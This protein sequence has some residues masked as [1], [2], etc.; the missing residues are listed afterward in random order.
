[1]LIDRL[2]RKYGGTIEEIL[3]H[4]ARA[5]QQLDHLEH[6]DERRDELRQRLES[7]TAEYDEAAK[8][9]SS[10]RRAAARQ[11]ERLVRDEL[12]QVGMEKTR[13]EI[14]FETRSLAGDAPVTLSP[15]RADEVSV[16]DQGPAAASGS[17]AASASAQANDRS[18]AVSRGGARGI[19]EIELRISPNPGEEPRPP[20]KIAS[21]GELSRL[22]L[23]LK[24]VV[25]IARSGGP[26]GAGR[27]TGGATR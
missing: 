3:A 19:D 10:R 21:G 1:T 27:R 15:G 4:G 12:A 5:R 2:K 22:M 7:A 6:A 9:L 17:G 26:G 13:F 24:T 11:I 8:T 25:G 16:L 23:A 18:G 20:E 14:H